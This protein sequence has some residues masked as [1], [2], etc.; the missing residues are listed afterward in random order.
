MPIW[1]LYRSTDWKRWILT[2]SVIKP[3]GM[4][5]FGSIK[6]GI[7]EAHTWAVWL[8][9]NS[10]TVVVTSWGREENGDIDYRTRA[11]K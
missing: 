8:I 4:V 9:D 1:S 7:G 11:A 5:F 3:E 10:G 2:Q 6:A